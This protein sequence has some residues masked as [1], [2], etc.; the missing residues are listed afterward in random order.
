MWEATPGFG[1]E[2][3]RDCL[4]AA[5]DEVIELKECDVYS[6]QSDLEN[7]PFGEKGLVWS[8]NY[9]F[10]NRKQKRILYFSCTGISRSAVDLTSVTTE[11]KYNTDD[12]GE[13]AEEDGVANSMANQ[14][15]L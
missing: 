13:G 15:D 2:P 1:E 3:F 5:I 7:D 12:E 4:W 9:F 8:F 10:Y 11:Y 14:M 6:Y